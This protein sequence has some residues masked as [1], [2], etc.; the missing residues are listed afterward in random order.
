MR[1]VDSAIAND[2]AIRV[3][4]DAFIDE[5]MREF[6]RFRIRRAHDS[7]FFRLA[8]R[9]LAR[10]AGQRG[11]EWANH[12]LTIVGYTLYVPAYW[13]QLPA[14][15]RLVILRHERVH[16]RQRR[17]LSLPG[18]IA[19]YLFL[20]VPVGLAYGRARLEWEAYR[21]TLAALLEVHGP[22]ALTD[23]HLRDHIV[24]QFTTAAYGWMWPFPEHVRA[25]YDAEIDRL[26]RGSSEI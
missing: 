3:K 19:L 26:L 1:G 14:Y 13:D 15:Q 24:S 6:P 2:P 17:R 8:E 21:A 7:H 11:S 18:M 10:V 22:Q 16:L 5:L 25:W 20:P 12:Y 23:A 4:L 9:C